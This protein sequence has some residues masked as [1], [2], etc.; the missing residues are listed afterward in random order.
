VRSRALDE[1]LKDAHVPFTAF[2]HPSAFGAQYEAALSHVPGRSWAKTVICFA[3]DQ[4]VAAVVPA[5]RMVD[6]ER[7]RAL[8]GATTLRLARELEL[9]DLCPDAEPGAISPF[10]G[11]RAW[12]VFVDRSFVGEPEMVFSAG[13]H[14]DAIRMH[15]S[16]FAE[17]AQAAVG[18]IVT[19]LVR[20]RRPLRMRP[21]NRPA[22]AR[23]A[24]QSA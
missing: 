10:S 2:R 21:S 19:P 17:L 7:L 1:L 24:S 6:L 15:Y 5:H 22:P 20:A 18:E 23:S 9:G 8:V 16:D 11:R 4:P 12:R 3:D 14:T 13:T